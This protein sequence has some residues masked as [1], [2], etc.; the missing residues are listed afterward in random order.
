MFRRSRRRESGMVTTELA[1]AIP[2]L[3]LVLV[4][5]L[6][7][8]L[9]GVDQIRCVDAARI[10][11]RAAARGDGIER[12]RALALQAAPRGASVHVEH[13]GR[14]AAVVVRA[15]TGGWGGLVPSW[16]LTSTATT[17]VESP[18]GPS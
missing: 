7:G 5:C 4:C 16:E 11:A 10:A 1:V 14:N 2:A 17:P 12:V 8:V 6:A 15:R 13:W 18:G 9:A 3:V